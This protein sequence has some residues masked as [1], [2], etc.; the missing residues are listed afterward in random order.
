MVA[1][2]DLKLSLVLC[3][4]FSTLLLRTIINRIPNLIRVSKVN[5]FLTIF[6]G[7]RFGAVSKIFSE[8]SLLLF[9]STQD[10]L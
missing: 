8:K 7:E 6:L 4:S 9:R 10:H 1:L 5:Q 3:L 2:A